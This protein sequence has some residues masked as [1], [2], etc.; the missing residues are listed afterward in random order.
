[1]PR[2]S[3]VIS[4]S[5]GSLLGPPP[6]PRGT[7]VRQREAALL[8]PAKDQRDRSSISPPRIT[9]TAL[10]QDTR[11]GRV[12]ACRPQGI[13]LW[14]KGAYSQR[15]GWNWEREGETRKEITW[16]LQF[17]TQKKENVFRIK[18][19]GYCTIVTPQIMRKLS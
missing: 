14:G 7:S 12:A 3:D 19:I 4:P 16:N 11:A 8:C 5:L 13:T 9:F 2:R 18:G 6:G 10:N 17:Q 15:K 1:M